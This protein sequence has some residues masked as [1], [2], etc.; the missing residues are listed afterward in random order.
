MVRHDPLIAPIVAPVHGGLVT[1]RCRDNDFGFHFKAR[2]GFSFSRRADN[3]FKILRL[4]SAIGPDAGVNDRLP[5]R[6]PTCGGQAKAP[7]EGVAVTATPG[8]SDFNFPSIKTTGS[9]NGAMEYRDW[10]TVEA[11]FFGA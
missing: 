4:I 3:F 5:L 9:E 8:R 1:F 7:S 6:V 11:P 2:K 10:N